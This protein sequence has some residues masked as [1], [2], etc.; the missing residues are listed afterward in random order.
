[1]DNPTGDNG[2]GPAR[3]S[4]LVAED[5]APNQELLH[6]YLLAWG[7]RVYTAWDGAQAVEMALAHP[8]DLI[9]M[10]IQMPQVDGLEAIRRIKAVPR[11][12][13]IPIIALT[14]LAMAGDRER[15]L[16]VGASAYLAKPI[17]LRALRALAEDLLRRPRLAPPPTT[18]K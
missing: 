14:A 12:A 10:D 5:N 15:C 7:C 13:G 6:D 17:E 4:I 2:A 3:L 1:M 8:L 16:E 18:G 11:L 9:I